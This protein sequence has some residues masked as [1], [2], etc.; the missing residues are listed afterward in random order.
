MAGRLVG[1]DQ[2]IIGIKGKHKDVIAILEERIQALGFSDYVKIGILPDMYP[3]GDEQV[4]VYETTGRIVP[5]AGIPINVGCVVCNV[6]TALNIYKAANGQ[7]VTENI[8]RWL[9]IF[10]TMLP[11]RCRW[12]RRF[13]TC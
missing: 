7:S 10:R 8:S 12:E 11:L 3:A 1:A 9:A 13:W 6:E 4:L 5:E 2:A